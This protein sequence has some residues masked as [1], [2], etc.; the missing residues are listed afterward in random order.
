M[1]TTKIIAEIGINHKGS[2]EKAKNLILHAT[3][4][5]C[6]G[7]KFQFRNIETFYNL[8]DLPPD[9]EES[10]NIYC[11]KNDFFIISEKDFINNIKELLNTI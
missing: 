9:I 6:W 2:V 7:V 4:T 10:L 1:A 5:N 8:E 3:E 11:T